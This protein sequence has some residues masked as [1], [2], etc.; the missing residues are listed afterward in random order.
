MGMFEHCKPVFLWSLIAMLTCCTT[1]TQEDVDR[2]RLEVVRA[3][4]DLE[5]ARDSRAPLESYVENMRQ[6]SL[7]SGYYLLVSAE[8]IKT[9]A[10]E[11]FLPYSYDAGAVSEKM[12]G[13]FKTMK[14][15]DVRL[16]HSNRV[17]VTL[18]VKGINIKLESEADV[19]KK[20]VERV[21]EALQ[22]GMTIE[23]TATLGLSED[24]TALV[25]RASCT[26]VTLHRHNETAYRTRIRAAID[27][28]LAEDSYRIE[29]PSKGELM[30]LSVF[31]TAEHVVLRYR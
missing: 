28:R 18:F 21:E 24:R 17:R 3:R 6:E 15:V 13:S 1:V 20:H 7:D 9:Q 29:L 11:A 27:S 30:P 26:E 10:Q 19:Y 16:L 2:I 4:S 8:T 22:N 23:V 25:L 12:S 5:N 31:T 14:V